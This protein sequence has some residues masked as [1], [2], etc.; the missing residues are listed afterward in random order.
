MLT[1]DQTRLV[2]EQIASILKINVAHVQPEAK[3]LIDL[4][5]KYDNLKPLRIAI[6][7]I[8]QVSIEPIVEH[9]N[10]LTETDDEYLLTKVSQE[11]IITYLG[12]WPKAPKRRVSFFVL[13]TVGMIE[14]MVAK[15]IEQRGTNDVPL[16]TS[17]SPT[18]PSTRHESTA[19]TQSETSDES[20]GFYVSDWNQADR[21]WWQRVPQ[22]LG[23][24]RYRLYLVGILRAAFQAQGGLDA[25][26]N[27]ILN[28]AEKYAES[29]GSNAPALDKSH[30]AV[31]SWKLGRNPLWGGLLDV[32]GP[33][34]NAE[35]GGN[36][37]MRVARV[38][39]WNHEQMATAAREWFASLV[40]PHDEAP[41][42]EADWRTPEI[43]AL[44][45]QMHEHRLFVEFPKLIDLLEQAGCQVEAILSHGRDAT[46]RHLRGD[47]LL[48][49]L[50]DGDPT[51]PV[52]PSKATM[53]PGKTKKFKLPTM[54]SQQKKKYKELVDTNWA[55]LPL[56][57]AWAQALQSA[58]HSG[59]RH[60]VTSEYPFLTK[61]QKQSSLLLYALNRCVYP[62][63]SIARRL[64]RADPVEMRRSLT[65][66]SRLQ[67]ALW[68]NHPSYTNL[69][70]NLL[71][72]FAANDPISREWFVRELPYIVAM[73]TDP[74]LWS[75][76][77]LRA[78]AHRDEDHIQKLISLW[79]H[80]PESKDIPALD[81]VVLTILTRNSS[82]FTAA[83]QRL[84]DHPDS[85]ILATNL[86]IIQ[87]D[88]LACYE[89]AR[90]L[91]PKIVADFDCNSPWPWDGEYQQVMEAADNG[92]AEFDLSATA[93]E[94]QH[95]LL[96]LRIPEWC[97]E[98]Q[99]VAERKSPYARFPGL[100]LTDVGPHP[101]KVRHALML[102]GYDCTLPDLLHRTTGRP[103]TLASYTPTQGYWTPMIEKLTVAGA[104]VQPF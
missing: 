85:Q 102:F 18:V 5:G 89:A 83:L 93:E 17:S 103:L 68:C 40:P 51:E 67:T 71:L 38:F 81:E 48:T 72:S 47:W 60:Y 1:E 96:E 35:G 15:A 34:C 61:P 62:D 92:L 37:L 79:P 22:K 7:E 70:E 64:K 101:E 3:F 63:V 20:V 43:I 65:L 98:V 82:T 23:Q 59:D 16:P 88:A 10:S 32:L 19:L 27:E 21:K 87:L 6:E 29:N 74:L 78:I 86:N 56:E 25:R 95:L 11:Q 30:R 39:D 9:I 75:A 94:M 73:D 69:G 44:A 55:G 58:E 77:S 14:A 76:V 12:G 42:L 91:D 13:F 99:K 97:R 26:I 41:V 31:N 24:D 54:T 4:N 8:L 53:G 52:K 104:R 100:L 50:L 2:R 28:I 33:S 45:R 36:M 49:A 90:W 66:A 84:L 80:S 57:L 46:R